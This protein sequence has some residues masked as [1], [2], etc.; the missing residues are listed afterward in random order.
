MF[1]RLLFKCNTL[2][3]Y[4][5]VGGEANQHNIIILYWIKPNNANIICR[6]VCARAWILL[7]VRMKCF[8]I[9]SPGN[10]V[11]LSTRRRVNFYFFTRRTRKSV[12][13]DVFYALNIIQCCVAPQYQ[14]TAVKVVN[15]LFRFGAR[16]AWIRSTL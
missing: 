11:P 7:Y 4:T 10:W 5:R 13:R 6:R 8:E 9:M 15:K 1:T 2:Y 12:Q 14:S 3:Y 16:G